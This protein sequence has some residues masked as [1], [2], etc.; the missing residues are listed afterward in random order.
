MATSGLKR[1]RF[2]D[3]GVLQFFK[4]V[5]GGDTKPTQ[6]MKNIDIG[7]RTI[8]GVLHETNITFE[9]LVQYDQAAVHV[10]LVLSPSD[11]KY[12]THGRAD[13]FVRDRCSTWVLR[14]FTYTLLPEPHS[15]DIYG[16]FHDFLLEV[17]EEKNL[18]EL[19]TIKSFE[20]IQQ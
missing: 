1:F 7:G 3:S 14:G 8:T 13:C 16:P 19:M 9:G 17:F 2:Y 20:R 11:E 4:E 18:K 10:K 5:L 15:T 12:Q 6:P